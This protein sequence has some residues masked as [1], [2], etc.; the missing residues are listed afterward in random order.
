MITTKF[1][2]VDIDPETSLFEY[3]ILVSNKRD[4]VDD[5]Q[6]I[7]RQ[8]DLFGVGWIGERKFPVEEEWFNKEGFFSYIGMTQEE[9]EKCA[10]ASKMHDMISYHGSENIMGIDYYPFTKDEVIE[11]LIFKEET[12]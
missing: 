10:F 3:G 6:V 1:H 7:Y 4:S 5:Y 8:G 2:G 12:A 11:F 9:W